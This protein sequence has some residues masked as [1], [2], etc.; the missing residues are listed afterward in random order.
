M[1]DSKMLLENLVGND[2]ILDFMNQ[3]NIK[4]KSADIYVYGEIGRGKTHLLQAVVSSKLAQGKS[5][6]Y[7]DCKESIPEHIVEHINEI[8]WISVDNI[9][10]IDKDQQHLFF[11]LY[12]K[13]KQGKI[14][15]LVSGHVLPSKLAIMNDLK[16]RLSL[17]TIFELEQLDDDMIRLVL[18]NQMSDRNL[19]I[20][21]KVYEYL[22]KHYS[23]NLNTLIKGIK[24]LDQS[25]LQNKQSITI[26]FAKKILNL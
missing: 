3:L 24:L 23:R 17:A 4:E 22:F 8:D 15:L 2:Q 14:S 16:T 20:D 12:N 1:L 25:S 6:I 11:D 7:L 5:G 13:A 21:P 10:F 9:N 18:N 19:A 26:P